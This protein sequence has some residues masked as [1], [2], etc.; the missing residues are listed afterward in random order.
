MQLAPLSYSLCIML[1]DKIFAVRDPYGNRPLCLGKISTP[2]GEILWEYYLVLHIL[3]NCYIRKKITKVKSCYKNV[4]NLKTGC[5]K[6]IPATL[7]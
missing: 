4:N 3:P 2:E 1:K 5:K 7:P 6:S